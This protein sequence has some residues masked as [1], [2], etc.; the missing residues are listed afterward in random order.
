MSRSSHSPGDSDGVCVFRAEAVG[1]GGLI[2]GHGKASFAIGGGGNGHERDRVR[3]PGAGRVRQGDRSHD[4]LIITVSTRGRHSRSLSI[5]HRAEEFS[6]HHARNHSM[7]SC[8][9]MSLV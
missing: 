4:R 7:R 5:Q 3:D 9:N 1:T 6:S 8:E 2:D